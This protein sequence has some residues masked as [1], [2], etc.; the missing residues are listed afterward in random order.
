MPET[1]AIVA[2][3]KLA[4]ELDLPCSKGT[5]FAWF[6]GGRERIVVRAD[7]TWLRHHC[8]LPRSYMGFPVEADEPSEPY[9][10]S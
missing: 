9:G 10:Q 8:Q 2:A 5:V 7:R 1:T 4:Q 6:G 3:R